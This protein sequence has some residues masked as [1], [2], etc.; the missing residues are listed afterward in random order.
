MKKMGV[1]RISVNPQTL[2]D[3]TLE[4]IGRGHTVQDFFDGYA[5]AQKH[6]FILN[7]DLIAGLEGESPEDFIIT[8]KQV[9]ALSPHNITLHTLSRKRGSKLNEEQQCAMSNKNSFNNNSSYFS[10]ASLSLDAAQKNLT[11]CG[12]IPYYLYRQKNMQD[13]LENIG[14]TKPGFACINNITV[15][16]EFLSVAACGAGAISKRIYSDTNRIERYANPKDITLYVN[17][18]LQIY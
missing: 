9:I 10:F 1:T 2:H 7:V 13:N 6:S 15:M 11:Q 18:T 8:L 3:K 16:E 12:Y 17:N 14:Y 4:V 5:L